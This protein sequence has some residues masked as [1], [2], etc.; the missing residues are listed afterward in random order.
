ME[1]HANRSFSSIMIHHVAL[2]SLLIIRSILP[3]QLQHFLFCMLLTF[4]RL[5]LFGY[6]FPHALWMGHF[7]NILLFILNGR[8]VRAL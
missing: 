8:T 6:V 2:L 7:A 3:W 5:N 4:T 1:W